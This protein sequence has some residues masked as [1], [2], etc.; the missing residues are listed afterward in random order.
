M[1]KV[2]NRIVKF[3]EDRQLFYRVDSS[4]LGMLENF[5]NFRDYSELLYECAGKIVLD[6]GCNM[7]TFAD[8]ALRYGARHVFAFEPDERN[9]ELLRMQPFFNSDRFTLTQIAV[10][11][12]TGIATL[13]TLKSADNFGAHSLQERKGRLHV[14]VK[15]I[16]LESLIKKLKPDIIKMDIEGHENE[17][18]LEPLKFAKMLAIEVHFDKKGCNAFEDAKRTIG[19]LRKYFIQLGSKAQREMRPDK[20]SK[21]VVFI[22]ERNDVE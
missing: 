9:C 10:S 22:G 1:V 20:I 21:T 6:I 8:A 18:N 17:I 13:Y 12:K 11:E 16:S 4:D 15:T 7:G 2:G 3:D 19:F 14:E 5:K